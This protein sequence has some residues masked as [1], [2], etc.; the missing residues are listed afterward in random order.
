MD[1]MKSTKLINKRTARSERGAAMIDYAILTSLVAVVSLGSLVAFSNSVK[2]IYCEKV[3]QVAFADIPMTD[4]F[5]IQW[6]DSNPA[7]AGC[8]APFRL[9]DDGGN[10]LF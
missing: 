10:R 4:E 5:K 6:D 3:L 1:I 8:F 2:K 9:T 7:E